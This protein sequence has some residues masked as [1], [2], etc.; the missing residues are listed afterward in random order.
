MFKETLENGVRTFRLPDDVMA[1]VRAI[2][3]EIISVEKEETRKKRNECMHLYYEKE[4]P[5]YFAKLMAESGRFEGFLSNKAIKHARK[6]GGLPEGYEVHHII[7][8]K[9]GGS[10]GFKNLCVVDEETHKLMHKLIY[11]PIINKLQEGER[12]V[13][14]LPEFPHVIKPEDRPKF[15]LYAELRKHTYQ[16][17]RTIVKRRNEN[18]NAN[19]GR[20]DAFMRSFCSSR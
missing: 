20:R 10:N 1:G 14:Y 5:V 19:M 18:L 6:K 3:Y 2:P 13:L 12:A 4:K 15:F 8:I 17:V 7:P 16:S 9:L 11:D